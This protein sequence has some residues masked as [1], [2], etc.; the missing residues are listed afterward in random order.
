MNIQK[1]ASI[2]LLTIFTTTNIYSGNL[3]CINCVATTI[4]HTKNDAN[5]TNFPPFKIAYNSDNKDDP[6]YIL[7]LDDNE[8]DTEENVSTNIVLI[9]ETIKDNNSILSGD[10][11]YACEDTEKQTLVCDNLKRVCECV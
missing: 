7:P 9:D 10:T 5:T 8:I 2:L 1:L 6:N 11:L 4:K 3:V